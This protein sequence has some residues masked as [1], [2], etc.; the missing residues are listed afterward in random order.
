MRATAPRTLSRVRVV[1]LFSL[2]LLVALA[3]GELVVRVLGVSPTFQVIFRDSIQPSDNPALGYELRPGSPDG[4]R[5]RISSTGLRDREVPL[6]KLAGTFRIAA[7]GDSVTY[8]SR[9][10]RRNTWVARLEGLL[11][12][13]AR[14]DAPRFEVLNFGVPGYHIGQVVERLR[15]Q[16][17]AHEPDLILYGYV[18]NDPEA[19]SIEAEALDDLRAAGEDRFR[20][21]FGS[22]LL[23]RWLGRSQ[24]FL[25]ARHFFTTRVP[26][27][28]NGPRSERDPLYAALRSGSISEYVR[29]LHSSGET[30]QRL[31]RGLD[32]LARLA[33][34]AGV[35][36]V[37]AIFPLFLEGD[38]GDYPIADVHALVGE[39]A[40]RRG[41]TLL[42]LREPMA[43]ARS[44]AD[45]AIHV[46]FVHPNALGN[47]AVAR[48]LLVRLCDTQLLPA[49]AVRCPG[50]SR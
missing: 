41:F 12:E 26:A 30:R 42:D 21:P 31:E 3:L 37:V 44:E 36:V 46:D 11:N 49:G 8:G 22:D 15:V 5:F 40:R 19:I 48:T 18:L 32:K 45:R 24:M 23:R 4:R 33:G 34:A 1:A 35:P 25:L 29:A 20:R 10:G 47:L 6:E 17:L 38:R 27:G 43:A 7:I 16:G 9:N 2:S 28:T 14:P 50:Q 39:E 13:R